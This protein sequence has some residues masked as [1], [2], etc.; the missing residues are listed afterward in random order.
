MATVSDKIT[1]ASLHK[2][3]RPCNPLQLVLALSGKTCQYTA[4]G[5]CFALLHHFNTNHTL[6]CWAGRA[7]EAR[8]ACAR[9]PLRI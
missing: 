7:A 4:S 1:H 8:L 5:L 3:R 2:W 6:G 9:D